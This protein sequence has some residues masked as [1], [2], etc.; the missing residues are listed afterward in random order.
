VQILSLGLGGEILLRFDRHLIVDGPGPDFTVFENAFAYSL[1]TKQRIYAEPGEVSV[2]RDGITYL[3]FPFDSLTLKGCAGVTPTNGNRNPADPEVSGGD[4]FDL[5]SLGIDSIRFVRIR[6]VTSIVKNNHDSPFWDQTLNGFDLDAVVGVNVATPVPSG[7]ASRREPQMTM[8]IAPNPCR[9]QSELTLTLGRA[10]HLRVRIVNMLGREET[11]IAD[12]N[13][14]AGMHHI[15]LDA[16]RLGSGR[17]N[18]VVTLGSGATTVL[19]LN[20]LH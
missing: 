18:V 14:D 20:V 4:S 1:G 8:A 5:A 10:D 11:S 16:A 3:P 7:I 2:S 13:L 15:R 6:D 12:R 9:S 19:P 17:Y